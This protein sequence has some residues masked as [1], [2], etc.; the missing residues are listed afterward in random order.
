MKAQELD[1]QL[2]GAAADFHRLRAESKAFWSGSEA[3]GREAE[4][5][6]WDDCDAGLWRLTDGAMALVA[7][8]PAR[9]PEGLRA[10]ASVAQALFLEHHG[11]QIE[12]G[13]EDEEIKVS[14]SLVRDILGRTA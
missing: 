12:E 5:R 14:L 10:K 7:K 2:I 9:T 11:G 4:E 1:G 3:L 6:M 8:L 13:C